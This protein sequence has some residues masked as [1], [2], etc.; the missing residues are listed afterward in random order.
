[1]YK[2]GRGVKQDSA[3][4]AEWFKKAAEQGNAGAQFNLGKMYEVGDGVEQD[5]V[6]AADWY[7]KA[8]MQK[9]DGV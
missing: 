8:A 6:K 2:E 1:M 4:A 7:K 3:K 9:Q 5:S